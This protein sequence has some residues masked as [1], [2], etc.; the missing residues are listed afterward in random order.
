[1]PPPT[2]SDGGSLRPPSVP[3]PLVILNPVMTEPGPSPLAKVT[4]EPEA[5]PSMTVRSTT[6]W[7]V[8]S[9]PVTVIALP[10]KSMFST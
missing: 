6:D 1:M 4:T 9:V 10:R 8:G 2:K 5:P 3:L 7:L